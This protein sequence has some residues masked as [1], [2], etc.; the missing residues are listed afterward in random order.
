MGN[1]SLWGE[2]AERSSAGEGRAPHESRRGE[3]PHRHAPP[4]GDFGTYPS[5]TTPA[6]CARALARGCLS[7]RCGARREM[8]ARLDA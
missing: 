3:T 8:G 2:A 5:T 1:P 6:R 4:F 7:P